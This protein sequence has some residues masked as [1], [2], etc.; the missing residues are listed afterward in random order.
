[1]LREVPDADWVR[2]TQA[3]FQP[4]QVGDRIWIVPSWHRDNPDVPVAQD[5]TAPDGLLPIEL[6][7][8]LA[9]GTGSHPPTHLSLAWLSPNVQGCATVLDYGCGCGILALADT[10]RETRFT[11]PVD[12]EDQAVKSTLHNSRVKRR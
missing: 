7:P 6:D 4:I 3:Q 9:F 10:L 5:G 2:L 1:M 8:A 12:N 11:P